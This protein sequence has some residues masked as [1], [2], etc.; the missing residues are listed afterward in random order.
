MDEVDDKDIQIEVS[1]VDSNNNNDKYAK[2]RVNNSSTIINL[3]TGEEVYKY[4]LNDIYVT[5]NNVFYIKGKENNKYLIFKDNKLVY[6]TSNYKLVRLE[7]YNSNI[8]V[9]LK[10]NLKYDYINLNTKK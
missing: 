2:I 3:G 1:N 10:S 7:D 8:L 9:C 6:E 5:D 4:T